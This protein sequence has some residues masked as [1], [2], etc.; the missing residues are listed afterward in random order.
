MAVDRQMVD[1]TA[2]GEEKARADRGF[3]LAVTIRLES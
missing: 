3:Q 2:G 1:S